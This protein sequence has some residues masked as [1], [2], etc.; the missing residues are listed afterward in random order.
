[1]SKAFND[2]WNGDE[3]SKDNLHAEDTP[4]YWAWEGWLAGVKAEREACA[5]I[6]QET[7]CYT[8]IPT[9]I[10]TLQELFFS[11]FVSIGA[12]TALV[13]VMWLMA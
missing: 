6:A 10:K 7:V 8:Y 11:L 5:E 4:A 3:M 12:V 2:W 13:F 1:M 9:G